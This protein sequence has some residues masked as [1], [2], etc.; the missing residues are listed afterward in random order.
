MS[1]KLLLGPFVL[2]CYFYHFIIKQLLGLGIMNKFPYPKVNSGMVQKVDLTCLHLSGLEL[3]P[4]DQILN[5]DVQLSRG[6][7]LSLLLV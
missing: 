6:L 4:S 2:L 5:V 1:L 7:L 3:A